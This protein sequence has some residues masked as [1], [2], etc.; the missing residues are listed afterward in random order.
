[1]S[2]EASELSL[3]SSWSSDNMHG[4]SDI[5]SLNGDGLDEAYYTLHYG[6]S[7][8]DKLSKNWS[9]STDSFLDLFSLS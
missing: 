3:A 5:L 6:V 9:F 8:K 1:M 4:M 7:Y 2:S